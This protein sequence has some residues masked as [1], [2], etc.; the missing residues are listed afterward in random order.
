MR[1]KDIS[2]EEKELK[3]NEFFNKKIEFMNK[4]SRLEIMTGTKKADRWFYDRIKPG[5]RYDNF[6]G[7]NAE[8]LLKNN[9]FL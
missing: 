4:N 9:Q 7:I 6:Y 5:S 2:L 1:S 3:M 8:K